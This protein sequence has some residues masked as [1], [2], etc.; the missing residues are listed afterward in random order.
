MI[1][2]YVAL[3]GAIGAVCRYGVV[4]AIARFFGVSFPYGTL[5]VNVFGSLLMGV[6]V[7]W[8]VKTMPNSM[9]LRAFLAVGLLGGFTTFSAFSLDSVTLIEQGDIAQA[10]GYVFA[11][12]L[13][14]IAALFLAL[15]VFRAI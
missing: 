13:G 12:V 1:V 3:G 9:E 6:L 11:S 14:S 4:S 5:F 2:A 10:I 7:G 15:M 8:L